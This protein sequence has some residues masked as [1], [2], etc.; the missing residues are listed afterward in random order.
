MTRIIGGRARGRRLVTPKGVGTRPTS[1]RVREA[2]F[3]A[4]E[5]HAGTGVFDNDTTVVIIRG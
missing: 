2:L 4:L 5:R 3:S 1:D